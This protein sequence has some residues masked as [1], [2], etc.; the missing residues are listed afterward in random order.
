MALVHC[1]FSPTPDSPEWMKDDST[2]MSY[3]GKAHYF[4]DMVAKMDQIVGRINRKVE[5]LGIQNKTI[6]IFT[7]DNGTD[8]P[9]VSVLNGREVAGAKGTTTDAGTRVPLIVKWPNVIKAN[10]VDTNLIDFSDFLPTICEAAN[11]EVSDTLDIDGHSFLPQLLG[12]KGDARK[13]IYCWYSKFAKEGKEKVFAR[14]HQYKL[15]ES[16]EFYEIPK[17]YKEKNPITFD[18][19]DA[20][21]KDTYKMLEEVLD[22]YKDTRLNKIPSSK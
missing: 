20:D 14:N 21:A 3:K 12:E 18:E 10:S 17:D 2:I 11:I 16:G 9:I 4:E 13:W 1:P 5:E 22:N 15:Y 19:L 6:V 8:R 7:G